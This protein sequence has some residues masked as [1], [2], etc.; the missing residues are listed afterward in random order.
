MLRTPTDGLAAEELNAFLVELAAKGYSEQTVATRDQAV[1][2]FLS[3]MSDQG[4]NRLHDVVADHLTAYR[5]SLI[6]RGLR[7]NT[8]ASYLQSVRRFFSYLEEQ[9]LV[10]I[11]P[12]A[13]LVIPEP[14]KELQA[15]PTEEQ[16]SRLLEQ[17]DTSWPYGLRDRALMEVAYGTGM[18]RG[19]LASLK[20]LDIDLGIGLIRVMGKGRK[21]RVVPVGE[22]AA[23]WVG[24]YIATA[25]PKLLRG[26]GDE[27]A[28]WIDRLGKP[29]TPYRISKMIVDHAEA[30]GLKKITAHSLRR[31]CVT[32]MLAHGAHPMQLRELLGHMS[33]QT[34]N[35]YLRVTITDIKKMHA[36]SRP[37]Q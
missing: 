5:L 4:C 9:Q 21:E 17:P 36:R 35:K 19:E 24:E 33:S 7:W 29:M 27:Q 34:L 31:A 26:D 22:A 18:R 13:G 8:I 3:F 25:R 37:G 23:R 10:F 20:I 32:H 6:E 12:A 11:N 15:V 28:V 16:V 2:D 1:R 30:A 14:P